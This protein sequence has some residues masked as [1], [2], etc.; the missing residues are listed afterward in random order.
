MR[1]RF[2]WEELLPVEETRAATAF[3]IEVWKKASSANPKDFKYSAREPDLTGMLTYY[4]HQLGADGRILGFWNAETQMPRKRGIGRLSRTRKDLSYQS[5]LSG[6]RLDLTFEFKKIT[7]SNL[8]AYRGD[9]G[10]K[11]FVDGDYAIGKPLA[12][13]V[14]ISRPGDMAPIKHL[15][16]SLMNKATQRVLRMV[17]DGSGRYLVEPS[18]AVPGFCQFDTEHNRPR[19]K[20]P[21]H[22]T[23][24]LGHIFLECPSS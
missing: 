5:N 3:M 22:G 12:F 8:G 18:E 24:T 2:S 15:R 9:G 14:G 13:M 11:R 17:R 20:A 19:G 6:G 7:T 16:R 21:A 1:R 4:L 23:I 10:M